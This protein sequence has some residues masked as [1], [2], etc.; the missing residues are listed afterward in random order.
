MLSKRLGLELTRSELTRLHNASGGN[1]YFAL[2]LG[3]EIERTKAMPTAG[4]SL[5]VPESLREVLGGRIAQLP[6]EVAD[7]LLEVAALARPTIELVAAADGISSGFGRRSRLPRARKLSSSTTPGCVS[8]IH[9]W[10][11]SATSRRRS[12][13]AVRFTGRWPGP[14]ATSRSGPAISRWPPRGQMPPQRSSLIGLLNKRLD[15]ERPAAAADLCELAVGLTPDDPAASRTRRLRAA[16]YH[17]LAGDQERAAVL[18]EELL[19]EVPPGGE[20]ADVLFELI[21]TLRRGIEAS[22]E[23][24][25]EALHEAGGDDKR[26]V[27]ILVHYAG[28]HIWTADIT[29][30]DQRARSLHPVAPAGAAAHPGGQPRRP[31]GWDARRAARWRSPAQPRRRPTRPVRSARSRNASGT[32]R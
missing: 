23:L 30:H 31:A 32:R 2:E 22:K 25:R 4:G 19:P 20:R 28:F 13:S 16:R 8:R 15:G 9:C 14:S 5:R 21:S 12:G 6:A 18:L 29:S 17:R 27:P 10:R 1:P 7:V 24:C 3:R 26:A 11:R